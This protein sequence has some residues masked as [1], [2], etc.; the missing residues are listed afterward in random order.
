MAESDQALES[1]ANTMDLCTL[2]NGAQSLMLRSYVRSV[3]SSSSI[4]Q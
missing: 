2:C 1:S 3:P 4:G